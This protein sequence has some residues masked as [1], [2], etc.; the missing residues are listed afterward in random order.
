MSFVNLLAGDWQRYCWVMACAVA[1]RLLLLLSLLVKCNVYTYSIT[2]SQAKERTKFL[3][4]RF[5]GEST[6]TGASVVW[7]LVVFFRQRC[8]QESREWMPMN[9]RDYSKWQLSI[10]YGWSRNYIFLCNIGSGWVC[11]AYVHI[12]V[13]MLVL[14]PQNKTTFLY[15]PSYR[16]H[17][18]ETQLCV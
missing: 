17:L 13:M 1:M 2:S 16:S 5:A 7:N 18:L 8:I 9:I 14:T 11:I 10:L 4:L 3:P 12:H 15:I 6:R